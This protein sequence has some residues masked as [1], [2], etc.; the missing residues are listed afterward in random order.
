MVRTRDRQATEEKILA[1]ATSEF[2]EYGYAGARVDRIAANAD[3]N[4]AMIYY[5]FSNK[6]ILYEK[7]LQDA[8][9][10]IFSQLRDSLSHSD[11]PAE[12]MYVLIEKYISL[13]GSI[14][15]N[16]IKI[17][18]RELAGGGK[19]FRKIALPNLVLPM[20]SIAEKMYTDGVEQGRFR[21]LNPYFT[22]FQIVGGIIFFNILKLPL[23][24]SV[25]EEKLYS[26]EFLDKFK[27]NYFTIISKGIVLEN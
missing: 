20:I 11:R 16:I 4:K 1:S 24:G 19:Y 15:S 8:T 3:I 26:G 10:G 2:A 7:V 5:Y 17:I 13:I 9:G 6:E 14:D 21:D 12:M 18:L 25:L 27:E 23:E 22:F